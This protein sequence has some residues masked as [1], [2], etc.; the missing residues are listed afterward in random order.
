MSA[1]D[2]DQILAIEQDIFPK[3]W[4]RISFE[5][6]LSCED[7]NNFIVKHKTGERHRPVIAY[8]SFRLVLDEMHLLK[9]GVAPNWQNTGIASWLLRKSM[10]MAAEKGAGVVY[11]EVRLS[12]TGAIAFYK[13]LGFTPIGKRPR[14]YPETGEDALV[15]MNR[16]CSTKNTSEVT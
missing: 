6:E 13:K 9:I 3:P 4:N 11:L 7:S 14:Y 10:L 5:N 8:I 2:I 16:I 15:L 1:G 12:N